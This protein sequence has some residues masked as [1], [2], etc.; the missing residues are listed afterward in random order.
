MGWVTWFNF[1][2]FLEKYTFCL[3][4]ISIENIWPNCEIVSC[5]TQFFLT[6]LLIWVGGSLEQKT[7]ERFVPSKVW[8]GTSAHKD[9]LSGLFSPAVFISPLSPSWPC[10]SQL[11]LTLGLRAPQGGRGIPP[12]SE[13]EG[14]C[15]L[16]TVTCPPSHRESVAKLGTKQSSLKPGQCPTS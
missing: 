3:V 6:P 2:Q 5:S 7:E 15:A 16:E 10:S 13:S 8:I 1:S 4:Q 14:N 11:G 12:L 9:D